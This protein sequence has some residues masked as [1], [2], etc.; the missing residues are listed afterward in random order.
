M[1]PGLSALYDKM[2]AE[3]QKGEASDLPE[4]FMATTSLVHDWAM[5]EDP[6][7]EGLAKAAAGDLNSISARKA[8][9]YE[10]LKSGGELS[11]SQAL[12][13]GILALGLLAAGGAI[14]GKRGL[15]M[16]GQSLGLGEQLFLGLEKDRTKQERA[17]V[18]SELSSLNKREGE[19]TKMAA[20][21]AMAPIKNEEQISGAVETAKR[22]RSAGVGDGQNINIKVD[23]AGSKQMTEELLKAEMAK[24]RTLR[25]NN[26]IRSAVEAAVKGGARLDESV[27]EA[28][29]RNVEAFVNP[30]SPAGALRRLKVKGMLEQLNTLNKGTPSERDRELQEI[31]TGNDYHVSLKTILDIADQMDRYASEG[32]SDLEEISNRRGLSIPG[33]TSAKESPKAPSPKSL[34]IVTFPNGKT[35]TV[36]SQEEL[37]QLW[38]ANGGE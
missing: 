8:D 13:L 23:T 10:K 18:T 27:V 34:K 30:N 15:G 22:K 37:N 4:N 9:L 1:A 26:A 21:N 28:V 17:S 38:L 16:A 14:K 36:S 24:K 5:G 35:A 20:E 2:G 32:V 29:G 31:A 25:S 11:D 33:S 3:L 12:G 19:I 6:T 7:R